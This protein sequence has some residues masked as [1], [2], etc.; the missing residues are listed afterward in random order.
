[1]ARCL[2]RDL[3][4]LGVDVWFDEWEVELGDSL[5]ESIGRGLRR[6]RFV[7][8]IVSQ[9]F[10]QSNWCQKEL[11]LAFGF[12]ESLGRKK[13]LPLT[14]GT[15]E[16]PPFLMGRVYQRLEGDDYFSA[17]L[18]IAGLVHR[19]SAQSIA[20]RRGASTLQSVGAVAEILLKLGW[21]R[22]FYLNPDDFEKHK[23]L[24][25][26]FCGLM[27]EDLQY[28]DRYLDLIHQ[29]QHAGVEIFPIAWPFPAPA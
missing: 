25:R 22:R 5:Y 3:S 23:A 13:V 16:M 11:E 20:E 7:V 10:V 2:A 27:L 18:R 8:V 21:K 6:S 14:A 15:T 28:D 4:S 19:Y 26:A 9:H 12:E 1:M 24:I 17:L 29:M